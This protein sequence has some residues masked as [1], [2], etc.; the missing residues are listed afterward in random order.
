MRV[1]SPGAFELD[2]ALSA[3]ARREYPCYVTERD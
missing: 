1:E 3:S 2:A